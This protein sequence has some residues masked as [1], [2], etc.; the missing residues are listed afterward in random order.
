MPCRQV[1]Q[2]VGR[3]AQAG[4]QQQQMHSTGGPELT[5]AARPA[6][7]HPMHRA[8]STRRRHEH[9]QHEHTPGRAPVAATG[10][11]PAPAPP[12][13][14]GAPGRPQTGSSGWPGSGRR[15]GWWPGRRLP[16]L[17]P[18]ARRRRCPPPAETP[19]AAAACWCLQTAWRCRRRPPPET[20]GCWAAGLPLQRPRARL[21][22]WQAARGRGA[23]GCGLRAALRLAGGPLIPA[24]AGQ[25]RRVPPGDS[26]RGLDSLAPCGAPTR[27]AAA[28][29][30]PGT[31]PRPAKGCSAPGAARASHRDRAVCWCEAGGGT[32]ELPG[33]GEAADGRPL[34]NPSR[35]A[36]HMLRLGPPAA[37]PCMR[38][39]MARS[40]ASLLRPPPAAPM[41][42]ASAGL[43]AAA[44]AGGSGGSAAGSGGVGALSGAAPPPALGDCGCTKPAGGGAGGSAGGMGS[45]AAESSV[46]VSRNC[47]LSTG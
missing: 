14:A 26:Q 7:Q 11:W 23:A 13:A 2:A 25:V 42:E 6:A 22:V 15:W 18:P 3:G 10:S 16:P 5:G 43:S 19:A 38:G 4:R 24:S 37:P 8:P 9:P 32:A 39:D 12:A 35:L 31:P 40:R 45:G 47:S 41:N 44:A 33:A 20:A 21:R 46:P 34:A 30:S 17:P 36:S 28:A 29:V 1:E 27:P